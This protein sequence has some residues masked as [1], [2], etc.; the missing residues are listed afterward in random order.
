MFSGPLEDRLAVRERIESYTD[1]VIQKDAAAWGANWADDSVWIV[2]APNKGD[3]TKSVFGQYLELVGKNNIV[4]FWSTAVGALDF[5]AFIPSVAKIAVEGERA[6]ARVYMTAYERHRDGYP[7]SYI[8][9]YDDELVK[10]R[11]VW[12]FSRRVHQVLAWQ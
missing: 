10:E 11:G 12:L 7:F 9:Q 1:P 8:G 3:T 2:N 4:E 5:A 6:S